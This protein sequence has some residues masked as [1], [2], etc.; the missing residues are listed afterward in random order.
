[1][2]GTYKDKQKSERPKDLKNQHKGDRQFIR[3]FTK[4]YV[5]I[6]DEDENA[7]AFKPTEEEGKEWEA[8]KANLNQTQSDFID[9]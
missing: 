4:N 9:K 8:Y 6:I 1:M 2:S 7:S 5:P 3:G